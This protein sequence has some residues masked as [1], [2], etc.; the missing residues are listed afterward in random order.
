MASSGDNRDRSSIQNGIIEEVPRRAF[1]FIIRPCEGFLNVLKEI[2]ALVNGVSKP[3]KTSFLRIKGDLKLL[4]RA[5]FAN[6]GVDFC[7]LSS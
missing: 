7:K 3:P 2:R 4:I 5:F 1:P 6:E